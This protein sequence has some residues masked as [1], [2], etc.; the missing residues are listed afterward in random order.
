MPSAP[1]P[2]TF[3]LYRCISPSIATTCSGRNT[4]ITLSTLPDPFWQKPQWHRAMS[5]GSPSTVI[6]TRPHAHSAVLVVATA[7]SPRVH[8]VRSLDRDQ[9]VL[10]Y[11][12]VLVARS[13]HDPRAIAGER[14]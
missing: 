14:H 4:A 8:S 5:N 12:P 2:L 3:A 13:I 6:W 9:P 1:S 7:P 11:C 10:T